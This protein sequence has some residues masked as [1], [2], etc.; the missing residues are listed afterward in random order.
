MYEQRRI[1]DLI[2]IIDGAYLQ[3]K[4]KTLKDASYFHK[5]LLNICLIEF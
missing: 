5:K 1:Y 3:K 4:L 2:N